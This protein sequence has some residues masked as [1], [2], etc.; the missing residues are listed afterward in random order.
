VAGLLTAAWGAF[1]VYLGAKLTG[2]VF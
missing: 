2:A 1:L